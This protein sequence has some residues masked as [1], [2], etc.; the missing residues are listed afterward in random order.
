MHSL[1]RTARPTRIQLPESVCAQANTYARN[2]MIGGRS[3]IRATE[4]RLA[5]LHEDQLTG[6]LC[7]AAAS[8]FLFGSYEPWRSQREAADKNP[9]VGD[10]GIDFEGW[11]IDVKGSKMRGS[12]DPRSYHLIVRPAELKTGTWYIHAL[13]DR[14]QPSAVWITGIASGAAIRASSITTS[15]PLA[16]AYAIPVPLLSA[17]ELVWTKQPSD[18][19]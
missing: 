11:P 16:G 19:R 3:H 5:K 9:T 4:D 7:H 13:V 15:G 8:E 14:D 2:A 12:S 6:Q 1:R 10:G 17:I 18:V